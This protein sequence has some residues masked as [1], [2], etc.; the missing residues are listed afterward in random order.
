MRL[1]I[2]DI[3]FESH[4]QCFSYDLSVNSSSY[5]LWPPCYECR[6]PS[7]SN[8]TSIHASLSEPAP[9]FCFWL[10][11]TLCYRHSNWL[12]PP[13]PAS[14]QLFPLPQNIH[15]SAVQYVPAVKDRISRGRQRHTVLTVP[16]E[17]S[18]SSSSTQSRSIL[19]F[20]LL[21][22]R[23]AYREYLLPVPSSRDES[24]TP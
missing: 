1:G 23:V 20:D 17:R 7:W 5:M 16:L 18:N 8:P 22:A 14:Q 24:L 13:N 2:V 9:T 6:V 4:F 19:P 3:C 12:S 11:D 21:P 10:Y 15:S